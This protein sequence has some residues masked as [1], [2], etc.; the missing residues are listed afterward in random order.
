MRKFAKWALAL[1]F[2]VA[3][4]AFWSGCAQPVDPNN[5]N[6]GDKKNELTYYGDI[7]SI[8][9]SKCNGCHTQKGIGPMDFTSYEQVLK[10]QESIHDSVTHKR[11]PPWKADDTCNDYKGNFDLT[12]DERS[13]LLKWIDLGAPKGKPDDYKPLAKKS[14]GLTRVDLT[15]KT[16]SYKPQLK[17]DDYRCFVM[18]WP[19]KE[20]A[21]IS[22]FRVKPGNAKI[23]HHVIAFIA[24]PK[25]KDYFLKKDAKEKGDGYTCYGGSG[26]SSAWVGSWAPGSL[27]RDYPAGTGVKVQPGSMLIVQVH[28]NT[29]VSSDEPDSTAVEFKLESKVDKEAIFLPYTNYLEWFRGK[30][31]KIPAGQTNVTHSF[32]FD[33]ASFAKNST[34]TIHSAALHMHTRGKSAQIF[35]KKQSKSSQ[36]QCVLNINKWD[37][38][39]Q[40][41]YSLQKPMELKPGD[42]LGITCTWDNSAANQPVINGK[43]QKPVD[44]HWGEGTNDEMCL[45]I[46]YV[47]CSN[48]DGKPISCG[49]LGNR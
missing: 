11:M 40:G 44:L 34:F 5:P 45:G 38:N 43:K 4:L 27:G 49:A 28:Y 17:P 3:L 6:T 14:Q 32:A 39:W 16:P 48:K 1:L 8:V 47:T 35:I 29:A 2:S 7:K 9:E 13:K 36:K 18:P 22:G 24:S 19:K 30:G 37:F 26:G 46:L 42:E 20:T 25:N 23:V 15:V 33:I 21:F 41:A 10:F 31:M 12:K